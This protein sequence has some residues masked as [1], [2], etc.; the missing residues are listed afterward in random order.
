MWRKDKPPKN[1]DMLVAIN[2]HDM[3]FYLIC[4]INKNGW[5]VS[6]YND[7]DQGFDRHDIVKWCYLSDVIEILNNG[8]KHG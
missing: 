4:K 7:E 1:D 8:V 3:H 5:L 6:I 2:D